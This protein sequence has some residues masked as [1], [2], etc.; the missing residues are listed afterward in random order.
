MKPNGRLRIYARTQWRYSGCGL[1]PNTLH[2]HDQS[3]DDQWEQI[4]DDLFYVI[5]GYELPSHNINAERTLAHPFCSTVYS[6]G[7][8]PFHISY[9]RLMREEYQKAYRVLRKTWYAPARQFC[10]TSETDAIDPVALAAAKQ[11]FL[12]LQGE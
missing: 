2:E 8:T 10:A 12:A 5:M 4:A 6:H 11:S 1:K 7:T 9:F 3:V